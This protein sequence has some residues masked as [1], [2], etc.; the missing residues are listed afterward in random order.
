MFVS[1][2]KIVESSEC[3]NYLFFFLFRHYS[4]VNEVLSGMRRLIYNSPVK[5]RIAN[6]AKMM[7][8]GFLCLSA[9]LR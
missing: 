6:A 9:M 7:P 8:A 2:V 3:H 1:G 4:D 5:M